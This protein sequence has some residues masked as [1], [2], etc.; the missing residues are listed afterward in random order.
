L[1]SDEYRIRE[2]KD[3]EYFVTNIK[4]NQT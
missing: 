3:S 2:L 1:D 4:H